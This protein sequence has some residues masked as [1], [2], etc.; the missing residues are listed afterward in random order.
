MS[1]QTVSASGIA[2]AAGYRMFLSLWTSVS[3]KM[4]AV[5]IIGAAEGMKEDKESRRS[6]FVW[7]KK[8]NIVVPLT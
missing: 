7:L 1:M 8:C 6:F 2:G 3:V 4:A 5:K